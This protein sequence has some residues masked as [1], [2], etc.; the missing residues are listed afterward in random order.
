MRPLT[1]ADLDEVRQEVRIAVKELG[2]LAAQ[3][4]FVRTDDDEAKY[5]R[6]MARLGKVNELLSRVRRVPRVVK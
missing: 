4:W 1:D 5:D 2:E 3:K 6:A